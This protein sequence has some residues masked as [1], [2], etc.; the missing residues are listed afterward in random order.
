MISDIC[1][2]LVVTVHPNDPQAKIRLDKCLNTLDE[3][4]VV[5]P[6]AARAHDLFGGAKGG[7]VS[8][9]PDFIFLNNPSMERKKCSNEQALDDSSFTNTV[10]PAISAWK[11]SP[12]TAKRPRLDRT[13]TD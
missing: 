10:C 3:M 2:C 7:G 12:K 4:K 11:F 1:L 8:Y 5:W 9:Q 6:S 13:R